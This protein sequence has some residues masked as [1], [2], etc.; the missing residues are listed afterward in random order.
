MS[1]EHSYL[2]L[3]EQCL[4]Y[5]VR[6]TRNAQCHSMFGAFLEHDLAEGFPLL[7]TKKVFFRGVVEELA[8]FLRG[9]TNNQELIDRGVHIW[10]KNAEQYDPITKVDCGAIYGFNWRFFGA[11][12]VDCHTDYTGQG[13][14]Q[15]ASII[16]DIQEDPKSRRHVLSAWNPAQ[17]ACLPPCHTLYQFYVQDNKLSVQMYQ[18]SSDLFLGLPFNIAS[19]A[20]LTHLISQECNL[21]LGTMRIIIGDAHIYTQH[22]EA[23]QEQL[24]RIPKPLPKISIVREKDGLSNLQQE[25]ITLLNYNPEPR[26]HAPMIV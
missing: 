16:R 18:R 8:W 17:P 23:V 2:H 3:L 13:V 9:S 12:Y 10:D 22:V 26:I 11:K 15:I 20:L 21:E 4:A 1:I 14:D 6:D 5:P 24:G 7:T 19:T 25:D